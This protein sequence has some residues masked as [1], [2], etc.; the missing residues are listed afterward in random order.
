MSWID[1]PANAQRLSV[2]FNRLMYGAFVFLSAYFLATG[3]YQ[4]AAANLGI[5]L[6]FDPFDQT[7]RWD[8]R[9]RWQRVWLVVHLLVLIGIALLYWKTAGV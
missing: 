2:R 8:H 9:P 6:I 5:S 7:V 3:S 1:Q 4:D